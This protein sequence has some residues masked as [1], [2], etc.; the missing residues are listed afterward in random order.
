MLKYKCKK[1][2][3]L[4]IV[5]EYDKMDTDKNKNHLADQSKMVQAERI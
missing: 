5:Y 2:K 4:L 1:L 3:I